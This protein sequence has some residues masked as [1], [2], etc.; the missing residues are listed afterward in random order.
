M[1]GSC[2]PVL[3]AVLLAPVLPR[4]QDHFDD[5]PG[6]AA[7]VPIVLTV[8]ALA[9]ALLA[10]FAGMIVDRLG[11]KR[12]L[13][14]ATV[15]Y[16]LFGT[17]PLWL[18]SL[19]AIL[20][21]RVLVGIAEAAI[22]TACTTLI[23]DYYSGELRDRYLALQTMCASAS[24][25]VFFVL[26][27]VLGAADWRAPFWLYAVGLLIAPLMARAL[28][29]PRPTEHGATSGAPLP[30]RPFPV[31][32]MAGVCLLTVFGAVVF[33][34][35]PVEMAYLL[36]DLGTDSTGTIGAVTAVASAATVLGSVLFTRLSPDRRHRLPALL[37]LC[38]AGFVLMGLADSLPLLIVGAVVNCVGT[39]LLLPSL[40][41]RAMSLLEF[42]DRGR[43]MGLWTAAFFLGEFLC[44]L[45]LLA[46]KEPAGSLASAVALLGVAT[47]V[48]AAA[49]LTAARR[50]VLAASP[51]GARP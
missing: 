31:R 2:L 12:L 7:L 38:A 27:G 24:A 26:G 5:V 11:R 14:A 23:G 3:G 49:L 43:G 37:L 28:P 21:S 44:P 17:A 36:D 34:T 16:A 47:A 42:A 13:V 22:M 29:A 41:T 45:V 39:G 51:G 4:M 9:L 19:H 1:A 48:L 18:D 10:P 8:P 33:Y 40:V 50:P 30:R 25:T 6:S 32:R 15:L 35:V 20:I 46:G